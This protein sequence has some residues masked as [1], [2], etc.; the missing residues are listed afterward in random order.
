[1]TFVITDP[2]SNERENSLKTNSQKKLKKLTFQFP[3]VS[4]SIQ[5][6][7][8]G[9]VVP[10]EL[11]LHGA[12]Q[13]LIRLQDVYELDI[14]EIAGG[15]IGQSR[16]AA[17]LSAQDCLFIGKHCFN[18]GVLARSIEWFEEAWMLAGEER[19]KSVSQDQVQQFLDHAAKEHD[20]RVMAGESSGN[21]FPRPV[22]EEPPQEQ[23][24]KL[25]QSLRERPGMKCGS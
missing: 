23:R 3:D 2:W 11:D 4:T 10:K 5:K 24:A 12:A 22:Y 19:N 13:A 7:R 15:K 9:S 8:L 25:V 6:L 20:E 14:A 16:S 18:G 1:M 17:R 21:L